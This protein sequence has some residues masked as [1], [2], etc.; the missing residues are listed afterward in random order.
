[1]A[2]KST[3]FGAMKIPFVLFL[4]FNLLILIIYAVLS[5][6]NLGVTFVGTVAG[7]PEVSL[8]GIPLT[9]I[10]SFLWLVHNG[11]NPL[12]ILY[13]GYSAA[14]KGLSTVNCGLV[15]LVVFGLVGLIIGLIHIFLD[16]VEVGVGAAGIGIASDVSTG[17]ILGGIG[18]G[19]VGV[20][21]VCA[22]GFYIIG[23]LV[24]FAVSAIGG[25]LGGAKS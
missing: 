24:N 19:M 15:G 10:Y 8:L 18:T 11:I 7:V 12:L 17:A 21:A 22:L 20:A 4:G 16:F 9:L 6:L 5:S 3:L 25:L 1:M 13:G 14:K 2:E 23:L